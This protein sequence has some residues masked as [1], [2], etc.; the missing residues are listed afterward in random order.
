MTMTV[1]LHHPHANIVL[2]FMIVE[3]NVP[4]FPL[5]QTLGLSPL[6][7]SERLGDMF[8]YEQD[9]F[10]IHSLKRQ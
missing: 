3:V 9:F 7:G 1:M 2:S 8:V 10:Y 5:T 4:G 6:I